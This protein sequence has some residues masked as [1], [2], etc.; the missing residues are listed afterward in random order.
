MSKRTTTRW[1]RKVRGSYLPCSR[2]GWLTYIPYV[3]YLIGVLVFVMVSHYGFWI[4]L[5]VLIPN[6]VAAAAI[7]NWLATN[8]S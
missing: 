8:K 1:F 3:T 5:Y 6:W 7:M 2:Q 4:S